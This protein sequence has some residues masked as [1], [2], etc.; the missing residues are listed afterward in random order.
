[1]TQRLMDI[2][3]IMFLLSAL[4]WFSLAVVLVDRHDSPYSAAATPV[5]TP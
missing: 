4:I 3:A 1:M 5:Q 2:L